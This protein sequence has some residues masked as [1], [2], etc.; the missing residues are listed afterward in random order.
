MHLRAQ[1][2]RR[3]GSHR[4]V[5]L[6]PGWPLVLL[7][8]G[9]PFWWIFG[10]AVL[11]PLIAAVPMLGYLLALRDV[12]LPSGF[13]LWL[14]FL[15][16]AAAGVTVLWVQPSG[17]LAVAGLDRLVP[18]G[19]RLAWYAAVTIVLL[20]IVNLRRAQLSDERVYRLLA[21]LFL[22]T[23]VG[24]YVGYLVP[25][26]PL[27]SVLEVVL[28]AGI[29]G[30]D[31]LNILIHP[32][33]AQLQ[34]IGVEVTR[35]SA[36]YVYANDWGANYG[37]LAPFFVL[38]WTG[39]KAGWRRKAFPFVALVAFP[40]IIFSL[41]R[42]LWL[43]LAVVAVFVAVRM[44]L[45]GRLAAMGGV[46]AAVLL[47]AGLIVA[48]PLGNLV[49]ERLENQHSNEGRS[50]LASRALTIAWEESP[51]LGFGGSREVAGNFY[52][53]AGGANAACPG[54]SPPQ[55]GTQGHLWLLVF[56]HGIVGA[57]WF[58]GFVARRLFAGLR[59]PSRDA[60]AMCAVIV[61]YC[62]VMFAYDLLTMPTFVLMI[63]IGL[64]WRRQS[65][66]LAQ[67]A[68]T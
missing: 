55:I 39:A 47:V 37:I 19:Y 5:D 40:P 63:T 53:I 67:G 27:R 64:L 11:G 35:P 61:F 51:I 62:T 26:L 4:G 33:L 66:P 6:L 23:V 1:A 30:N 12:R 29:R 60:T 25:S 2:G 36:P 46:L 24:G 3:T 20:Y 48:T 41:N 16:W 57:V 50:E 59:D 65:E 9:F 38:A 17:T 45:R 34:D 18:F 68:T 54:C 15:V 58:L 8:A 14:L 22:V 10:L 7:F 52:S 56:G 21:F 44:A 28:P 32:N 42:G 31:F 13:A 43:G 49:T